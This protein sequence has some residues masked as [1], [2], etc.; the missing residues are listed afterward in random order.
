VSNLCDNLSV[1]STSD[2]VNTL[3]WS[4]PNSGCTYFEVI[5]SYKVYYSPDSTKKAEV[6]GTTQGAGNRLFSYVDPKVG[7]QGCFTVTALDAKGN[8]STF[9]NRV[10]LNN[11]NFY[12]LPNTFTPNGD[13]ANDVFKPSKNFFISKISMRIYNQWGTL[14]KEFSDPQINWDGEGSP[15]GTYYYVCKIF[16]RNLDGSETADPNILSGFINVIR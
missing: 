7:L 13:G 2:L 5:S 1:S 15:D 14:I 12:E 10:C 4:D 6:V 16:K 3:R 8:E 11:C 9:S